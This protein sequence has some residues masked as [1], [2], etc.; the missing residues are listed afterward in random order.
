MLKKIIN[1]LL[2]FSDKQ[3]LLAAILMTVFG[4][5]TSIFFNAKFDGCLDM[6]F[7]ENITLL[8]AI[9]NLSIA[10]A[11]LTTALF[12]TGRALNQ[13][14]RFLD[15]LLVVMI[16][17]CPLYIM[18]LLNINN[19][20]FTK[21]EHLQEIMTQP[22]SNFFKIQNFIL[23]EIPF[24]LLSTIASVM[25]LILMITSLYNGYKTATNLKTS[26]QVYIFGV[27]VFVAEIVSKIVFYI[28]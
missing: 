4:T 22:T 1:P 10:I 5:A 20:I 11:I 15:I 28:L 12:I 8:E 9:K 7:A 26:Q 24:L 3:L 25:G 2:Y 21:T 16:A 17:R 27:A 18:S 6:H 13:R 23:S 14:T 19:Y